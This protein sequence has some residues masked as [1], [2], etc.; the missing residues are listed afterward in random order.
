MAEA[1]TEQEI[2]QRVREIVSK[3]LQTDLAEVRLDSHFVD[4]LG[5]DSLDLTELAVA[6]EDGFDLEIPDA[7]FGR[8][9]TV[10]GVVT[11]LHGRL[12]G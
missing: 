2:Q 1:R 4:D 7:D 12:N 6:F 5:A 9:T 10:G 11:Y 3:Y 8:I